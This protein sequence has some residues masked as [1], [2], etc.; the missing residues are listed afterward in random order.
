M[1]ERGSSSHV[2]AKRSHRPNRSFRK[3]Q[4]PAGSIEVFVAVVQLWA[5]G[6][7]CAPWQPKAGQ[8]HFDVVPQISIEE[9]IPSAILE[10]EKWEHPLQTIVLHRHPHQ[11]AHPRHVVA[12][13]L[14]V[15]GSTCPEILTR[16]I[17]S[18]RP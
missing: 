6:R 15:L 5:C 10:E 13:D 2:N 17:R 9:S 8:V 4:E 14:H 12:G 16:G 11:G 3:G 7:S 1:P 18:V